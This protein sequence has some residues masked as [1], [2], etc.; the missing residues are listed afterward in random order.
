M[1]ACLMGIDIGTSACKVALFDGEGNA[2]AA[3]SEEYEVYSPHPGWSEQ[4]PR[5][6]W[7]AVCKAI[8]MVLYK[9]G[10]KARNIVGIGIDGQSWSAIAVDRHGEVLT[11]TPI[12]RDTRASDI[13]EKLNEQIGKE[14]IFELA[15][16]VLQPAY[17]TAKILWYQQNLPDVYKKTYKILQSNSFIAWKLTGNMTQDNSQGYGLHCFDMR[18]G[19]WDGEMCRLLGINE[20]LLPNIFTSDEIIGTVTEHAARETGLKAGIPVVAG[21]L[22]AACGALGAGVIYPGDTQEQ[23]GQA[24]GMSICMDQYLS[25]ER[26][27][28]SQHVVPGLWLLQGGTTGGGGVMR[29][30]EQEFADYERAESIRC[31]K[32]SLELFDERAEIVAPGSDGVLF[33]PY[34]AGE[35]SPIWNSYAKGVYYGLDFGKTK[36]HLIRAAVEGVALSLKHNLDIAEKAGAKVEV[37]RSIGGSANSFLWTQIK[38]DVTGK[39]VEVPASDTATTRGAAMLAGVGVN[40]YENYEKAIKK[41]VKNVRFHSPD[42]T[43]QKVYEKRYKD[44]LKLYELLEELMKP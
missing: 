36:G 4:D 31:G 12:W 8:N 1:E 26:L 21:G 23:G 44:Y 33:L 20:S 6:W 40:L 15:G 19:Q 32:S 43:N 9:A 24:G 13:C 11:N 38:A 17:T 14:H 16:N 22:D 2:L 25:D 34:M 37:L 39:K 3:S 7:K 42:K 5:E 10:D 30:L 18:R 28:L 29:W 35:R 27:I 41:T